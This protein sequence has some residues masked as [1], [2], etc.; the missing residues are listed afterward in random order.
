MQYSSN[1][2]A[3]KRMSEND[4]RERTQKVS[5]LVAI[6]PYLYYFGQLSEVFEN[7]TKYTNKFID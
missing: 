3:Y 1:F 2:N 4:K 6:N 7:V 5:E